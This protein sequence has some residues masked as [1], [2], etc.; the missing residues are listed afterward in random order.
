MARALSVLLLFSGIL[1]ADDISDR[2]AIDTIIG[3]LFSPQVRSDPQRMAELT[4]SDFDGGLDLIPVRTVWCEISCE[5]FRIRSLKF[6]TTDVAVVD[7]ETT[8]GSA[9]LSGAVS[10]SKWL[11]IL[12]R[13]AAGWRISSIRY[14]GPTSFLPGNRLA[15]N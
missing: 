6:V 15:G 14:F 4:T 5:S 1:S 11:M 13:D 7:G 9:S 10:L 2:K 12:K 3:S 8:M